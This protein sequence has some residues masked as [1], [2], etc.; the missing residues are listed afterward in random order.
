MS[1]I[2]SKNTQPEMIVRKC[3]YKQDVHYRLHTKLPGKPDITIGK[4]KIAIFINGCFWHAH[5]NCPDFRWPKTRCEFWE[6]KI[7]V[8]VTRDKSNY[9]NL[10]EAGGVC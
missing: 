1:R 7:I 8:N 2:R 6:N 10:K 5:N 4:K 3:L 9:I